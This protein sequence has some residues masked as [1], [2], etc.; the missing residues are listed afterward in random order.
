MQ[1]VENLIII[2]QFDVMLE[3]AAG[4]L[5]S[6]VHSFDVT[7]KTLKTYSYDYFN[8]TEG[9]KLLTI[10]AFPMHRSLLGGKSKI[11]AH[12]TFDS[13][14]SE[15]YED[16]SYSRVLTRPIN[17]LLSAVEID[18]EIKGRSEFELGSRIFLMVPI[19]A[20]GASSENAYDPLLTGYYVVTC[21]KHRINE[22]RHSMILRIVTDSYNRGF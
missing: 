3:S 15:D 20:D 11:L 8:Q 18:I 21:I 5:N 10:N 22:F 12:T 16:T 9:Q 6:K 17:G 1:M 4:M 19:S 14:Y 7:T 13:S 2:K